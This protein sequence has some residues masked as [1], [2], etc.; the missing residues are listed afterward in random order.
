MSHIELALDFKEFAE[1]SLPA[2]GVPTKNRE[3]GVATARCTLD[4]VRIPDPSR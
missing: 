3:I 1:R 4:Q 2:A